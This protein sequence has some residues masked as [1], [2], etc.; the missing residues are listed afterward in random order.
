MIMKSA[1]LLQLWRSLSDVGL[2]LGTLFFVASL[3]PTLIPRTYVTQGVLSGFCFWAGYGIGAALGWLWGYMGLPAARRAVLAWLHPIVGGFCVVIAAAFLWKAAQWQNSIR[4]VMGLEPV[5]SAH[6][7][8]ICAIALATFLVLI[9]LGRCFQLVFRAVAGATGRIV[10]PRVANVV[11]IAV[12]VLLFWSVANGVIFRAALHLADASLREADALIPPD[13][14]PPSDPLK[15]GSPASLIAWNKL[16]RAGREFVSSGPT[17]DAIHAFTGGDAM[18]P[19]RVYV[20]LPAADT[21]QDRAR[22]ALE[23]LKRVGAFSRAAL[24]V[25]TPTGTGWVDPAAVDPL[26]YLYRGD[27]AIVAQQYSYLI[28]PLSLV[29]EPEYGGDAARA[30][31][32]ET[33]RYWRSL[34]KDQRPKLY[35]YG[36][37]LGAMN[38]E[39]SAELFEL[40]GDP[41]Q[42][43]LWAGP[44]FGSTRWRA[45]TDARNPGS[46]AWLPR[47][48]DGAFV[49][50]M[51]QD[52][53]T[54]PPGTPWGPLRIVY[55]QYASDPI[56][57]FAY[58]DLYRAPDWMAPPRGPDV[59]P[60]LQWYPVVT[61]LQLGL[62]MAMAAAAPVGYGHD[63]AP[64]HY[65]DA[66]LQV[67][68][69]E[70][71]SAND[72]DRLKRSLKK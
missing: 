9:G 4:E 64:Q 13:R 39:R 54:V 1:W 20:G 5:A 6:P 2:F 22:L 72:I 51:N 15:T 18:Q 57:F 10:P 23:E 27:V 25:V 43:A 26:E 66:W 31:F 40:L 21:A 70:D 68:G 41:I 11:G 61:M 63:Y 62:D 65:I 34:P 56:T 19:I 47:F 59:S 48:R 45:L 58:Q 32:A 49:R 33:Y 17:A 3:T 67:T 35:L 60:D 8:Y 53:S 37:S 44:P 12:A 16:G 28:S 52:G 24:V 29:V 38:S 69:I 30:L 55:L 50:F 42:G 46:P 14:E 71:W 36:L 7:W